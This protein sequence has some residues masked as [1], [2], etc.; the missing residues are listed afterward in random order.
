MEMELGTDEQYLESW[1]QFNVAYR[2]NVCLVCHRAAATTESAT[3]PAA[4]LECFQQYLFSIEDLATWADTLSRWHDGEALSAAAEVSNA[5]WGLFDELRDA[6]PGVLVRVFRLP[7]PDD[8]IEPWKSEYEETLAGWCMVAR[9]IGLFAS[10]DAQNGGQLANRLQNKMKHGLHFAV[11]NDGGELR[12]NFYPHAAKGLN[13]LQ[14]PRV[15]LSAD[16]AERWLRRTFDVS[17]FTAAI[18][19]TSFVAHFQRDPANGWQPPTAPNADLSLE[20]I[21][22]SL[23]DLKVPVIKWIG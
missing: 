11:G 12:A 20:E 4:A 15:R 5:K 23:G 10:H 1:L 3:G 21:E 17:R 8:F 6:E 7:E 19:R 18:L 22:A 13:P 14:L 16:D 9:D 2:A